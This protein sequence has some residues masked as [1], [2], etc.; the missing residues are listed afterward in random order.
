M[1]TAAARTKPKPRPGFAARKT[2]KQ[3]PSRQR[4][5]PDV[6]TLGEAASFLRVA[7]QQVESLATAQSLPGRKLGDEWRFLKSALEDWLRT[8]RTKANREAFL[9]LAGAYRDDPYLDEIVKEAYR[10]RGRPITDEDAE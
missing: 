5:Y 4:S 2:N 9:A 1:A 6:L 8:P 10:R 7:E 3:R